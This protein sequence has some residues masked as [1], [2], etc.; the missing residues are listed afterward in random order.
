MLDS[1]TGAMRTVQRDNPSDDH[2]L[3]DVNESDDVSCSP[4]AGAE[5]VH[6]VPPDF[7][8]RG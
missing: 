1:T 8:F 3:G 4:P 5:K 7:V 6:G 2:V